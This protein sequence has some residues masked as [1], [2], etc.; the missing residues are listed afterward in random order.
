MKVNY[1]GGFSL[2]LG[3]ECEKKSI[4]SF[5]FWTC[6][7][8]CGISVSDQGLNLGPQEWKHRVLTTGLPG[9]SQKVSF[10]WTCFLSSDQPLFQLIFISIYQ[11]LIFVNIVYYI[12]ICTYILVLNMLVYMFMY[13]LYPYYM[14]K[15]IYTLI[16]YTY[17]HSLKSSR[18]IAKCLM[19]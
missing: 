8:A 9:N 15:Y 6:S 16:I 19:P 7:M 4:L 18:S 13:V 11:A 12:C 17:T 5:F 10:Q 3:K 14:Y 2:S 1:F